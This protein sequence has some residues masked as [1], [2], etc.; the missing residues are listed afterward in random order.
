MGPAEPGEQGGAGGTGSGGREE[1]EAERSTVQSVRAAVGCF[2]FY[3]VIE[4]CDFEHSLC[5]VLCVY[6]P[7]LS[8]H[9]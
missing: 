2:V 9:S 6:I 7:F 5:D 4:A 1:E 8:V 3:I